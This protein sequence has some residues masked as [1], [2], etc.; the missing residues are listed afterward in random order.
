MQ[1]RQPGLIERLVRQQIHDATWNE[2]FGRMLFQLMVPHDFKDA[3]RQFQQVV[4]VVDS[5]TANLPW[6]LMLADDPTRSDSDKR[7][8]ALRTAVVRQLSS[9]RFR[10]QVR[11]NIAR[12]ALVIGNPS[13]KGF[14]QAFS[15]PQA[16]LT[17]EPPDLPGAKTEAEA[18]VRLLAGAGYEVKP[19]VGGDSASTVLAALYH[20]PWR[21]LHISAH[22]VFGL[23]HSDGR[24]RSGVLLSDGLL[25]TAAE[26]EAMETVPDVVF[27]NCCHLGTVDMGSEGNKL[28]SSV[29]REL[30]DIGVRCV[31]VAGWAVNDEG[32]R[33]F[34]ETFYQEMLL[35]RRPFGEAVFTARTAV[36]NAR[37]Q[38]ITWGAFQ[39]YGDPAFCTEPRADGGGASA[40][41]FA[42]P[43][44]LLDELTR[45]RA[46]LSRRGTLSDRDTRAQVDA[47]ASLLKDRCQP[48]WIN[49]PGLQSALGATWYDLREFDKA[50]EALLRAVRS[51]DK[52]G[53]VPIH[54]IEKLANVEARLG[55]RLA[56]AE[57]RPVFEPG[58]KAAKGAKQ[59]AALRSDAVRPDDVK[60]AEALISLAIQRLRTLDGL[61]ARRGEVAANIERSGLLGSA[62]KRLANLYA[63]RVLAASR[64]Q[65]DK[66]YSAANRAAA[67][68]LQAAAG[69]AMVTALKASVAAYGRDAGSLG[70]DQFSGYLTLNRLALDALTPWE[71]DEL[72][73]DAIELA[74]QCATS[75]EQV[76]ARS[77][78]V[79]E[80][81]MQPEALLVEKLIEGD[82]GKPGDAGQAVLDGIV[83]AYVQSLTNVTIKPV[84]VDSMASQMELLS[85]FCDALM[86]TYAGNAEVDGH[87]LYRTAS[88]LIELQQ[89]LRPGWPQRKDRPSPPARTGGPEVAVGAGAPRG[90]RRR[91]KV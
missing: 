20:Q 35:R 34:G 19:V 77:A 52:D 60:S 59:R 16:P 3:A 44:E 5:T 28:A 74:R 73:R 43:E 86:L 90:A 83:G 82:L 6:E 64:I 84:Q 12:T 48:G 33:L 11:Q 51:E 13:S 72:K 22:G 46:E 25:I 67:A 9:T 89:R 4:L 1:Q 8:L 79:W 2:D 70:S 42:S 57:V 40:T 38:D 55:E 7:P 71:G 27:L 66:T 36:W 23:Q 68:K 49:A 15:T 29:S 47:L 53:Q 31:V 10:R 54:D 65:G 32:A 26:I 50:R 62:Y 61:V 81:V 45:V 69:P 87:V 41:Q 21:I 17:D 14:V 24:F 75:A 39:A 78:N 88:R 76:Y 18:V 91:R 37:P 58:P 30:I 63:L 56:Q 80:A 85:R